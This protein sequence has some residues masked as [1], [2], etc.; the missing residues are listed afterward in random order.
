MPVDEYL[1]E[2]VKPGQSAYDAAYDA[3]LRYAKDRWGLTV[4]LYYTGLTEAT[5][6]ALDGFT[7]SL[8]RVRVL[9]RR[10]DSQSG[11]YESLQRREG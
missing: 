1:L 3:A 11:E 6:G 10:Y 5:L 2:S 8:C 7:A 4:H 9:L